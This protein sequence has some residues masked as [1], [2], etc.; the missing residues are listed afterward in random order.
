M[1]M[2]ACGATSQ[3][4]SKQD[5]GGPGRCGLVEH[6]PMHY[7]VTSSVPRQGTYPVAGGFPVGVCREGGLLSEWDVFLLVPSLGVTVLPPQHRRKKRA[8]QWPGHQACRID[9]GAG[10]VAAGGWGAGAG[11]VPIPLPITQCALCPLARTAWE[12]RALSLRLPWSLG[13]ALSGAARSV[14]DGDAGG[15]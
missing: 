8:V 12:G 7:K 6:R 11:S 13:R 4:A 1:P 14:A 2:P 5:R 3:M 9:E 15:C 10:P